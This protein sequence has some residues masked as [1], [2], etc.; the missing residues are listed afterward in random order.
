MQ[1]TS[2]QPCNEC[3]FRKAHPPGWLGPWEPEPL[4]RS[5]ANVPF[6]CHKSISKATQDPKYDMSTEEGYE[7][8]RLQGCAGA[9]IFLNNKLEISRCKV[10]AQHQNL[11]DD[12]PQY[13]KDS[14][15][16]NRQQFVNHHDR[17]QHTIDHRQKES[18]G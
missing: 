11:I 17:S 13:V 5:I 1:I 2:K 7:D 14:V 3:P 12:I 8:Q 18:I 15:F 16:D 6:P 9:A 4:L 10:T